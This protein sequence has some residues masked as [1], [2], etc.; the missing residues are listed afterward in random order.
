MEVAH[1][2][3]TLQWTYAA[4]SLSWTGRTTTHA[5]M[6]QLRRDRGCQDS[7]TSIAPSRR[8]GAPTKASLSTAL[9]DDIVVAP[10]R[11]TIWPL[12]RRLGL[13]FNVLEEWHDVSCARTVIGT[14]W[15]MESSAHRLPD[16]SVSMGPP[17]EMPRWP[18][19]LKI[20]ALL[21][22]T[23][24]AFYAVLGFLILPLYLR[25]KIPHAL[26]ARLDRPVTVDDVRFNPFTLALSIRHL[27]ISERDNTPLLGFEELYV[28]VGISS[29]LNRS[30]TFDQIRLRVPY[31]FVDIR[32][33]GGVNL[34]DLRL[35][36]SQPQGSPADR[37]VP[38][39]PASLPSLIIHTLDIEQG[40]IEFHD[41]ARPTPF[42]ADIVPISL[43]LKNF[44]TLQAGD[45][46][47]AFKAEFAA[48]ETLEWHGTLL[49]N[50]LRSEGRVS[51]ANFKVRHAWE[52]IQDRVGFEL[53]DGVLHI[54]AA[55]HAEVGT[56]GFQAAISD[57]T[58]GLERI[59]L[60]EKKTTS[61]LIDLPTF[62]IKGIQADLLKRHVEVGLVQS[63]GAHIH[64]SMEKDGL[65]NFQRGFASAPVT[66]STSASAPLAGD[67]SS[68]RPWS[69]AL[70][71][72]NL[73][74]YGVSLED[75]KPD[76]PVQLDLAALHLHV[77]NVTYPPTS[78]LN[79]EASGH[80]NTTGQ[81]STEGSIGLN[82]TTADLH[83]EIDQFPLTPFQPYIGQTASFEVRDGS[84]SLKGHLLYEAG[85]QPTTRF[86][87]DASVARLSIVDSQLDKP[88]LRWEDLHATRIDL[89]LPDQHAI[90]GE[91]RAAKLFADIVIGADR[92][93]NISTVFAKPKKGRTSA[94]EA[95]PHAEKSAPSHPLPIKIGTVTIVDGS[96]HFADF[97][98]KPIVDTG[99]FGLK[100]SIKG[101]SSQEQARAQVSLYGQVDKYAPVTIAGQINPLS[102]HTFTDLKVSFKNVELTTL[103]PYSTKFA[104]YPIVK[105][106]LSMDLRYLLDRQQLDADNNVVIDQ[107]T[108]GDKI[109]GPDATSLPVK[110][111]I[112][113][114][115]DR[116]GRINIDLPVKGDL[117]NPEFHYGKLIWNVLTNLLT[118][119]VASPFTLMANLI[120]GS[121]DELS[122]VPFPVGSAEMP[123]DKI[124]KLKAL[125]KSLEERPALQ[126][127]VSGI[128]DPAADG[129]ALSEAKLQKE[130]DLL[131]DTAKTGRSARA[132]AD[133][134]DGAGLLQ[135]LY[136]KKFGTLPRQSD[137]KAPVSSDHLKAQLLE[138]FP[139]EEKELRLLAEER[140]KQIQQTLIDEGGIPA[141]RI[142]LLG[143][144]LT[145]RAHDGTVIS[146]LGLTAS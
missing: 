80:I 69:I 45:N 78:P 96:A 130:L 1:A 121:S 65:L 131:K 43:S 75:Q 2:L 72:I 116:H 73:E 120:G 123:T 97:S 125:A 28:D 26:S 138:A 89:A 8:Q 41:R 126:L 64:A 3:W 5:A 30:L 13:C 63:T 57:G 145:G 109:E 119:A 100:G 35:V 114:L 144:K 87:G 32:P 66:G 16:E 18:R 50:P 98:V 136:V 44:R 127:E 58:L 40:A 137:G 74:N 132:Q 84:A 124:G 141:D 113:L 85:D 79:L 19:R 27:A 108:L 39:T 49:M 139:V 111:A 105:G 133:E 11:L 21:V 76:L 54:E 94:E 46:A 106:K 90:I 91:V 102:H 103:S 140:A 20:A 143:G 52:Y 115:K 53:T 146:Q 122:D 48:G 37:D 67:S 22:A 83:V 23:L 10:S 99:I 107:L 88:L 118:K 71:E 104:G 93:V 9:S 55:Y 82:P 95:I 61:P 24:M 128:A 77:K 60:S 25:S 62:W 129:A 29:L 47:F 142:F 68:S 17:P 34:L 101:L 117:S 4:R 110:F 42:S 6:R 7:T 12:K 36:S 112:A 86:E 51:L 70:N 135:A 31:G 59:S 56:D 134:P 81:F 38:E 15:R 14:Q 33:D 92:Q